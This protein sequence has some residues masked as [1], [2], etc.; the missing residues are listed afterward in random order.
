MIFEKYIKENKEQ[1]LSEVIRYSDALNIQ[2]DWLMAVMGFETACSFSPNIQ[3]KVTRAIG[4]IQFM[5]DTIVQQFHITTEKMGRL[6]NAQQ[7]YYVF[8]YLLPFRNRMLSVTD[9]Y[10]AVFFPA[11]IAKEN[12]WK[13]CSKGLSPT[14]IAKQNPAFDKNKDGLI[15]VAE[16]K[17]TILDFVKA[18][19]YTL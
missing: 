8:E 11:A 12:D 19:G 10:F 1:F 9:V 13:I 2:P 5:P 15:T 7:L 16:V 14:L 4:L 18:H 17:Q 6:T 3:N